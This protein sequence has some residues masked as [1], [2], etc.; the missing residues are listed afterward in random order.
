MIKQNNNKF[1]C[2]NNSN[3]IMQLRNINKYNYSKQQNQKKKKKK[4]KKKKNLVI[5]ML[6]TK[7]QLKI[8]KKMTILIIILK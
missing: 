8:N 7:I 6:N 5:N 2:N 3:K 1:P 4:K